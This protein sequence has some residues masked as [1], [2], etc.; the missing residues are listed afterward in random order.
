MWWVGEPRPPPNP[1]GGGGGAPNGGGIPGGGGGAGQPGNG[2]GGGGGGGTGPID[3]GA[4][5][6]TPD[7]IVEEDDACPALAGPTG[8]APN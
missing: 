1:R 7:G 4:G 6:G 2:G 3:A 5:I 8:T